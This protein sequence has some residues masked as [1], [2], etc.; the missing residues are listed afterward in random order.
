[1]RR[2]IYFG[3]SNPFSSEWRTTTVNETV[4]LPYEAGGTY[5]GFIDWGDGTTSINS[6]ANRTH[7]YATAGYYTIKVY[8][9]CRG[10]TFNNLGDK[11]K[12]YRIFSWGKNFNIGNTGGYFFGCTNLN[13]SVVS[14]ILRFDSTNTNGEFFFRGCTSLTTINRINEWNV[15]TFTFMRSFFLLCSNFNGDLSSW[16]VSNVTNM[17]SMFRG[18]AFNGNISSWNVGNVTVLSSMFRDNT[19]FNQPLNLWNVGNVTLFNDMFF[20]SSS[21]NQPLNLWNV[22]NATNMS[23]M[24]RIAT[25][26]NQNIGNWDIRNVTNFLNF[27]FGKTFSNYSTANYNALL[28]G[29]ASRPV[30][31]NISINFGTIKR[32]SA[33]T[34]ARLILTSSPN[35]WTIVDGGL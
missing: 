34:S 22:L 20:N 25:N 3:S 6:F 7:T 9:L 4:T 15:S 24:F 28:I 18:T 2:Y 8:G 16:N 30:K 17:D 12:I 31:P 10:F 32:T 27:M 1:M 23:N 33:A 21:F 11:D 35:N 19:V 29:W 13:L 14:D 26:F 5:D